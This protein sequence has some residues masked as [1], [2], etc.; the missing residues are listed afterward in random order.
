M[1]RLHHCLII[2]AL[3]LVLISTVHAQVIPP[4]PSA[5]ALAR[6][7]SNPVNLCTGT[8]NIQAPLLTLPGRN[9][10]VPVGLSYHASGNKVQDVSGPVG[11]GF[12]L[13]AGG[14]ITR[15]VK[16]MP[17]DSRFGYSSTVLGPTGKENA[18]GKYL[19]QENAFNYTREQL[20]SF[21]TPREDVEPDIFYFNF[22]GRTG[23][24]VLKA[25]GE[26]VLMPYQ[27]I[28]IAF[29]RDEEQ[30]LLTW[31]ITTEDGYVSVMPS[32]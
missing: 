28:K 9:I 29:D 23:R 13:N 6:F 17:D 27:D 22:M 11:L 1:K 25:N 32:R 7:A 20:Y 19:N 4:S 31:R 3:G 26:P 14:V 5:G 10:S 16:K 8:T 2:A 21:S 30:K 18:S 12:A 15:M 24:F